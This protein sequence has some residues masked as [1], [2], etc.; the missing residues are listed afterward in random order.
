MDEGDR[1]GRKTVKREKEEMVE[2]GKGEGKS[3]V[4]ECTGMERL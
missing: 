1:E 4:S 2:G 3:N